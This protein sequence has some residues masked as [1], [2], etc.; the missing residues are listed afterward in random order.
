[1]T[2]IFAIDPGTIE[3]GWVLFS[4]SGV[5]DSG[6]SDNHDLLR[7]VQAGQNAD[8]L[9]IEV[10]QASYGTVG[11]ETI[12]TMMWAGRFWQAWRDP[13][14]VKLISR[15]AAKAHV[16]NGNTKA[17]DSGVRQALLE[18]FPAT[19]GGKTPQVGVKSRPGPLYGVSSHAWAA[20]AVAVTAQGA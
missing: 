2:T 10:M 16:C 3:S 5:I 6:V 8:L 13:A 20:L 9:A 1:M 4:G 19:G 7:W 11:R 14:S 17:S 18:M 15:Q 12:D